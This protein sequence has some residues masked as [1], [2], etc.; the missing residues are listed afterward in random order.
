MGRKCAT[1]CATW[2][3]DCKRDNK[4]CSEGCQC[5]NRLNISSATEEVIDL[6][7]IALEEDVSTHNADIAEELMERVFGTELETTSSDLEDEDDDE[8]D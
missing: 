3:C 5:K 4:Q 6:A 8:S 2:R 7:E 1:G